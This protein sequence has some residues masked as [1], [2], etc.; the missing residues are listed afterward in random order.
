MIILQT[1]LKVGLKDSPITEQN[2]LQSIDIMIVLTKIV[3]WLLDSW[4][5][6]KIN[7]H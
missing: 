3:L 4:T 7:Y 2:M 1:Q 6:T 5:L